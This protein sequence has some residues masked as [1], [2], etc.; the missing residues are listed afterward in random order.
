[1]VRKLLGKVFMPLCGVTPPPALLPDLT[2]RPD[3]SALC[4]SYG[5]SSETLHVVEVDGALE[6]SHVPAPGFALL[7]PGAPLR[8]V[9]LRDDLFITQK[10]GLSEP[11]TYHFMKLEGDTR[12]SVLHTNVQAYRRQDG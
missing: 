4:G 8:L 6:V 9:P 12:P 2:C 7:A 1:M 11:V 3:L 5:K 10:P